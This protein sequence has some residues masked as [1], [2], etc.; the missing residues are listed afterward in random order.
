M[1]V[2]ELCIRRDD[3]ILRAIRRM[4]RVHAGIAFVVEEGNRLIGVVTDG[5][6]R[7]AILDGVDLESPVEGLMTE[8][9]VVVREGLADEEVVRLLQ[10]AG[11][12][13]RMPV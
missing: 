3:L 7:R 2:L 1:K 11:F 13:E 4:D 9:P 5:D 8:D 10:S 6:I 12:Q